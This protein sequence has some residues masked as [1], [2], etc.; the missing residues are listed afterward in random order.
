[1]F[2]QL[3]PDEGET[4][5]VVLLTLLIVS[6]LSKAYTDLSGDSEVGKDVNGVKYEEDDDEEEEEEK[7]EEEEE[8]EEEEKEEDKMGINE[9]KALNG[10]FYDYHDPQLRNKHFVTEEKLHILNNCFNLERRNDILKD[11]LLN[12]G[13]NTIIEIPFYC[14]YGLHTSI[15]NNV[16]INS[17][18]RFYDDGYIE[19]DEN[20]M[21]GPDVK[22][23]TA[24]HPIDPSERMKRGTDST[25]GVKIC[26]DV[27]ICGGV[28]ILP[29]VTIGQGTTIGAG[30][31]VTKNIPPHVVAFGNPCTIHRYT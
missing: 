12:F 4:Y 29:G 26:K 2:I 9:T 8:G 5:T 6:L 16:Y 31:V 20:V 24:C 1:M 14:Y 28:I 17:H 22:I 7:E 27:W 23:Y 21:I 13:E 25:K 30:S 18:C 11:I 15:K 19:I 3:L 10:D